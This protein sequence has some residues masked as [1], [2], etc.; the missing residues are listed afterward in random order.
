VV[1]GVVALAV[2]GCTGIG[3][4][5][6]ARGGDGDNIAGDTSTTT[7]V[8]D[9]QTTS[10]EGTATTGGDE[11][12]TT[13]TTAR[14]LAGVTTAP[15]A[16]SIGDGS[17]CEI[18]DDST[19]RVELV[20]DSPATQSFFLTVGF[21]DGETRLG[22]TVAIVGNLRP[23]ERTIEDTFYF[24]QSG[25]RCEILEAD[26][27]EVSY[28]ADALADVSPCE[29]TGVD[30]FGDIESELSV[31]NSGSGTADYS[32]QLS[33]VDDGGIRRGTGFANVESVRA[34]ETAPSD[35]FT[36]VEAADGLVCEVVGVDRTDS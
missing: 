17:G 36:V 11:S 19:I 34:G 7:A 35:V 14:T 4:V 22:D 28:D 33:F 2:A 21:F 15:G 23:G 27:F 31:T 30:S 3:V 13:E 26:G 20:N 16:G 6:L 24:D 5:A 29:V 10:S 9:E 25:S 12:S 8:D 1:L 18:I 32:V